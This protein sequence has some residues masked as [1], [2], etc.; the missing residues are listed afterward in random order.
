MGV[1]VDMAKT[2]V[3]MLVG[4]AVGATVGVVGVVV[5]VGLLVPRVIR[6]LT[7]PLQKHLLAGAMLGGAAFVISSDLIARLAFEP[8]EI[9]VGL[10]TSVFGGPMFV[11]LVSR[12]RNA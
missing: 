6:P 11:W 9:P 1:D 10:V 8:I 4:T 12:S 2:I 3:L 5:F 7:G